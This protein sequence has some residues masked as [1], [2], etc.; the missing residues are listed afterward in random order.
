MYKDLMIEK[1]TIYKTVES[2]SDDL[3]LIK[4]KAL[5]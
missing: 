4:K 3:P 1:S 2:D 5:S